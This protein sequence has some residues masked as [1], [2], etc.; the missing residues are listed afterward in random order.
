M[1]QVLFIFY[2]FTVLWVSVVI[3][4]RCWWFL[5]GKKLHKDKSAF[6]ACQTG[7]GSFSSPEALPLP[8][9]TGKIAVFIMAIVPQMSRRST[10]PENVPIWINALDNEV[11]SFKHS[12]L[13]YA[14]LFHST[15]PLFSSSVHFAFLLTVYTH[16][17]SSLT[18]LSLFLASES[19]ADTVQ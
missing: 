4:F 3:W 1:W 2:V 12:I 6:T 14:L 10:W 18:F 16:F 11:I 7:Q 17:V 9:N 19:W 5:Q 8:M 13:D 15:S